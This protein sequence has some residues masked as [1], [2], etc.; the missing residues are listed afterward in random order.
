MD[1][2]ESTQVVYDRIQCHDPENVSKIIEHLLSQD[3]T[4]CEMIRL[5]HSPDSTIQSLVKKAKVDLGLSEPLVS[6]PVCIPQVNS[7][8]AMDFPF[9]FTSHSWPF[10][11]QFSV[12]ASNSYWDAQ[13]PAPDQQLAHFGYAVQFSDQVQFPPMED[14]PINMDALDESNCFC[15]P[16]PEMGARIRQRSRSLP[17]VPVQVCYHFSKG[18]CRNGSKCRF[19]HGQPSQLPESSSQALCTSEVVTNEDYIF[20]PSFLEKLELEVTEI[21]KLRKGVPVSLA[22]LPVLY[23]QTFG[24]TLQAYFPEKQQHDKTS[25]NLLKLLAHMKNKICLIERYIF[26]SFLFSH[27]FH[28]SIFSLFPFS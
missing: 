15:F 9:G 11:S 23:Y 5:A 27:H 17:D 21:L 13:V 16:G 18:Y 10:N 26:V 4:E 20:S 7:S 8:S 24:K 12:Q 14:L 6:A 25:H 22:S 19:L 28:T 1:L 3:V 2:S